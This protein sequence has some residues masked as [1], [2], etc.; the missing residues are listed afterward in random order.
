ML[1]RSLADGDGVE[2]TAHLKQ[3]SR[4][5]Q[6]IIFAT[7][8]EDSALLEATLAG[9]DGYLLKDAP[10][11]YIIRAFKNFERGG[12]AMQPPVTTCAM[13]LL[14]EHCKITEAHAARAYAQDIPVANLALASCAA[15]ATHHASAFSSLSDD[16]TALSSEFPA[17]DRKSVV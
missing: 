10:V 6:V 7:T 16:A 2:L 4:P 5:P 12:P 8:I 17:R 15:T 11:R 9:V 1:F 13:Q 14:V 3:L